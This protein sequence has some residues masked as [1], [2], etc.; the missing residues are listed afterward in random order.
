MAR[1]LHAAGVKQDIER[2]ERHLRVVADE[3][4]RL[5]EERRQL[6]GRRATATAEAEAAEA[7]R[8]ACLQRVAEAA[9][10]LAVARRAAEA[11]SEHL[12]RQHAAAAAASERR[13]AAVVELRRME[14]EANDLRA[15][16]EHQVIE[17]R[18][19]RER[20][21]ELRRSIVAIDKDAETV[22]SESA[23]CEQEVEQAA[24]RLIETRE[25]S[26]RLA[27]DLTE[28]NRLAASIRDERA[29]LDVARAEA[30][31]R[32]NYLHEACVAELA[33]PL[34]ELSKV[35][36]LEENFDL[37]AAR[38]RVEELRARVESFGAVNMMALEELAEAEERFSFLTSQWQDIVDGIGSTEEALRE[39]KRRSR[40]RFRHAFEVV[41]RNFA[42]MFTEL[43]GGGRG[44]MSLIDAEDV[45]ESG[46]DL[47]AQP[48]GK[49][50]QNV[51]LLSGGEK[52]MAALALLLAIFRYRP[53]PFCLLD[54]VDAPLDEANVGRFTDKI[55]EMS[56]N[57][58]FIVVTH[59][60]KTMEAARALY[61]VTM[62]EAGISKVV[63]VKFE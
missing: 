1:E 3:A 7:S 38:G 6:E 16:S 10:A 43:F 49:R 30:A 14:A 24:R 21:E 57:T 48:P 12:S 47:V 45:L 46:I 26:D 59:N 33:Q 20:I 15:R 50:L 56:A 36:V 34:E 60:K 42:E 23:V 58:Q 2:A 51:L 37:E 4:A 63:S 40:E 17:I 8:L 18:T 31:A 54:E 9:E 61:G 28:L 13:R 22:A 41:N 19:I 25:R 27:L 52:A 32:L 35:C 55:V 39:I 62:E 44:E 53:S 29:A 5:A 11:E